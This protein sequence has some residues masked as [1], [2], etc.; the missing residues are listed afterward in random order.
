MTIT[1]KKLLLLHHFFTV[2]NKHLRSTWGGA[3]D[4]KENRRLFYQLKSCDSQH[5]I[6]GFWGLRATDRTHQ[7]CLAMSGLGQEQTHFFC[8]KSSPDKRVCCMKY[9]PR[10]GKEGWLPTKFFL[11]QHQSPTPDTFQQNKGTANPCVSRLV[12]S[13]EGRVTQERRSGKTTSAQRD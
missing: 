9:R 7:P 11:L 6:T 3:G 4:L 10:T 12:S 5:E 8:C 1:F 13:R 2:P